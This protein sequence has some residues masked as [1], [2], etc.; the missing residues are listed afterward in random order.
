MKRRRRLF[1]DGI[2]GQA[3]IVFLIY[4]LIAIILFTAYKAWE[5]DNTPK[6]EVLVIMAGEDD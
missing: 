4:V 2:N 5:A 1:R 3:F 6:E